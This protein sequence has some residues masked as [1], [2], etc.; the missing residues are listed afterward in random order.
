MRRAEFNISDFSSTLILY[1]VLVAWIIPE[2]NYDSGS[3]IFLE[4]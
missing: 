1:M 3:G 2:N 4:M